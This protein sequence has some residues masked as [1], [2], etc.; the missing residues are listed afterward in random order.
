MSRL[1]LGTFPPRKGPKAES[2]QRQIALGIRAEAEKQ[3]QEVDRE[4]RHAE[5][6]AHELRRMRR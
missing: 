4:R 3:L 6:T 1:A 5:K 2:L